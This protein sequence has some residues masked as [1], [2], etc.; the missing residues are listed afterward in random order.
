MAITMALAGDTMLGRGVGAQIEAS[1]PH[2]LFSGGVRD[3]FA[4]ADL[5][6]LNLECCVS[7]R[8]RPWDAPG[9]PFH[10]RAPPAAVDVLAELG[11]DCVTVANN[12]ALDYGADA[13]ADTLDLLGQAG[14]KT[15]GAG[16]D[17][18]AARAPAVLEAQGTR[19]AVVGVTDHPADFAAGPDRPGVAFTDLRQGVPDDLERRIRELRATAGTVLVMPHWG[20]NMTAEPLPYVR[21]AAR[22][23]VD[24][25]ASLVAG[26]SAHVFHGVAPPVVFDMGDFIDDYIVDPLLRN[27]LGLLF[28]VTL[29]EGGP[30]RVEAVPL[31]LGFARTECAEG[32]DHAWITERFTAAC[33]AFGTRVEVRGGRLVTG[34]L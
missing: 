18:A 23:L 8:G 14:I 32:A 7:E 12:H 6:L 19:V 29:D 3:A 16:E 11:V 22:G 30:S 33:R 20:P 10:F 13:L 26:S 28:L 34:G 21:R 27:D 25:G 4:E 15:V 5:A 24:A 9:K 31:R 17:L 1:G 2:G